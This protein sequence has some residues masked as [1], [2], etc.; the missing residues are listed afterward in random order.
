MKLNKKHQLGLFL[1]AVSVNSAA[2]ASTCTPGFYDPLNGSACVPADPGFF[3]ANAG[4]TAQTEAPPGYFIPNAGSTAGV[5]ADV[6]TYVP[7]FAASAPTLASPGFYVPVMGA[8]SQLPAGGLAAPLV[9]SKQTRELFQHLSTNLLDDNSPQAVKMAFA[10]KRNTVE[11]DGLNSGNFS[12]NLSAV[13]LGADLYRAADTKAGFQLA[14][15]HHA[16]DSKSNEADS[17]GESYQVSAYGVQDLFGGQGQTSVFYG[18]S[19]SDTTRM[20]TTTGAI[21]NNNEVFTSDQDIA[22]YGAQGKFAYPLRSRLSASAQLGVVVYD[23]DSVR[24]TGIATSGGTPTAAV[25]GL[26]AQ[27]LTFVSVPSVLSITYD[28][29][30]KAGDET[31]A[32]VALSTGVMSDLSGRQSMELSSLSAANYNFNLPVQQTSAAAGF[33]ELKFNGW[34]LGNDFRVS[35]VLRAELGADQRGYQVGFNIV[36]NW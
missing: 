6:G 1:A 3:V 22:W 36:K 27:S 30:P 26:S 28:L 34:D 17:T 24:E 15:A 29:V 20:L 7:G 8:S 19:S 25:G 32:P 35:G 13:A 18:R 5:L 33:A 12:S 11:Q 10:V 14:V 21:T 9:A 2:S 23:A 31:N 4:A 16:V